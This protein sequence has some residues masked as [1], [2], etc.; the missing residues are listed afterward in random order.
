MA[1]AANEVA[2]HITLDFY[3]RTRLATW[4][5]NH[6]GLVVWVRKEIGRAIPGWQPYGAWAYPA[7][8]VYLEYLLEKGVLASALDQPK[9]VRISRPNRV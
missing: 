7:G 3:D 9:L 2:G 4:V 8:G 5:R 6:A 1:H